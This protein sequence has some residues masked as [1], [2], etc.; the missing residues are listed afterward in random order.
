MQENPLC[1]LVFLLRF[2]LGFLTSFSGWSLLVLFCEE[3]SA[4]PCMK[5][6]VTWNTLH[7]LEQ[8][9][10]QVSESLKFRDCNQTHRD[11]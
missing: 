9:H 8:K 11:S 2:V 1:V 7:F 3:S 10:F 6:C 5:H 4:H